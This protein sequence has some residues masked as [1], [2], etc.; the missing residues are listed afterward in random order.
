MD[1]Q[2]INSER[3]KAMVKERDEAMCLAVLADDWDAVRAFMYKYGVVYPKDE[4]KMKIGIYRAVQQCTRI[5]QSVKDTAVAK[6]V[7][8]GVYPY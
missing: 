5:S 4:L 7:E 1:R 8:L 6:C 3:Y 2:R